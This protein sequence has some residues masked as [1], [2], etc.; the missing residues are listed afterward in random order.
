[1][2]QQQ[3]T[4]RDEGQRLDKYLMKILPEAGSGFL[5]KML[6]KKNIT[7][8]DKKAEGNEKLAKGDCI[9]IFFSEETLAKFMGKKQEIDCDRE[10]KAFHEV[11]GISVL[12]E[13]DHV[14]LL[15][16]PAGVLT[17]RATPKDQSLNEWL[18][19]YLLDSHKITPDDLKSFRPSTCNRL[20]RNTSG[21]VLCAKTIKGAQMLGDCLQDRSLHKYYQ[22]YVK[23]SLQ[24]EQ[25]VEGY[26]LKDEKKNKVTIRKNRMTDEDSYIKTKYKSLHAE[27]DK[28]LVE[29]ELM[30]GKTHQI[31][32]H[33]ASIGHPL[34]GDY[35]YGN[36]VFNDEYKAKAGVQHQLLHAYK[37]EFPKLDQPFEDISER[38]FIAELPNI[39][40]K[41]RE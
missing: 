25:L 23:G 19:G 27:R 30:T 35:K 33:L 21:I 24:G 32:A 11:K 40:E 22:L 2:Y 15:N 14:I 7:L 20:D 18:V 1:M 5:H 29:V 10:I 36:P 38:T 6:R 17:Q 8:N 34:L 13:N 16:K 39:F 31:R 41:V 37:V 3:I 9:K 28:T 26:L 4:D 12:F